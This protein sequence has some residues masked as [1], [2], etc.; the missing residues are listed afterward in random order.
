MPGADRGGIAAAALGIVG[1][2]LIGFG[3][4]LAYPPGGMI[5]AGVTL[6]LGALGSVRRR[7]GD[8]A[9]TPFRD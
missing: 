7:R 3:V 5:A 6:L 8:D 4:G 1:A 2:A 9:E